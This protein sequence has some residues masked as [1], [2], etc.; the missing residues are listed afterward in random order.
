M[1]LPGYG[2]AKATFCR[3]PPLLVKW[4]MNSDS[5]VST[6][7]PAPFSFPHIPWS[8][9]EPSPILVSKVMPSSRYIMAPASA[10]TVSCGSSPI[11]T[12]CMSSPKIS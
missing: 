11:S 7:F 10:I 5:P 9:S 2:A 3:P 8:G 1:I 6:R 4:V 12:N